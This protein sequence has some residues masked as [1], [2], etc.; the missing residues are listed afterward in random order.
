[1]CIRDRRYPA[2]QRRRSCGSS[3]PGPRLRHPAPPPPWRPP[4]QQ[5]PPLCSRAVAAA[6]LSQGR[7]RPP[8]RAYAGPRARRSAPA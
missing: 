7:S 4:A 8:R 2:P 6:R 1:M 5:G 3:A